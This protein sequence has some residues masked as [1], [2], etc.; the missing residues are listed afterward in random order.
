MLLLSFQRE[1]IHVLHEHALTSSMETQL[2]IFASET[3]AAF[4]AT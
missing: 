2:A 1:R 3:S 4:E